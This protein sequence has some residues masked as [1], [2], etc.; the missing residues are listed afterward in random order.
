MCKHCGTEMHPRVYRNPDGTP[1][2]CISEKEWDLQ[3]YCSAKCG[4]QKRRKPIPPR[5]PKPPS[6]RSVRI[7]SARK[8][9]LCCGSVFLPWLKTDEGGDIVS[10]QKEVDWKRQRFCSISCAKKVENP[11]WDSQ[12]RKKVSRSL[13]D[14][15][16][17]PVRRGGNG[18]LTVPQERLLHQ[19]GTEWQAELAVSTLRPRPKG[20]PKNIKLDI[21]NPKLRIGIEL[22]GYTHATIKNRKVDRRQMALLLRRGWR[23]LRISNAKALSLCSTCKSP[24][25]LRTTLME[26]LHIT[27]T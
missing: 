19:L 20:M 24:D 17:A 18:T 7:R 13:R 9:C 6:W 15:G 16:H 12:V 26:F 11:M 27:A 1:K 2:T 5:S 23:V 3:M 10:Y 4:A 21:A 14:I 8:T 25:T 22:D